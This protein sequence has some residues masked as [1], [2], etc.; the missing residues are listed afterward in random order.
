M[1][2]ININRNQF[3]EMVHSGKTVLVEFSAPWCVYCRR[4]APALESVAEEY[5]IRW[6][7]LR[8]TLMMSR[9]WRRP[10]L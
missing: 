5:K 9:N 1:A 3:E 2:V 8:L 4:L 6:Y 7:S 10:K